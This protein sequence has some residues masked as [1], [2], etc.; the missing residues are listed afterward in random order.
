MQEALDLAY[1]ADSDTEVAELFIEPPDSHV[2]TDE[3]SADEDDGGLAG[4]LSARQLTAGAEIR[5]TN[6]RRIGG[7][8][9]DLQTELH[10]GIEANIDNNH[11]VLGKNLVLL[12]TDQPDRPSLNIHAITPDPTFCDGDFI[13][14]ERDFPEMKLYKL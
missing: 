4:N 10:H 11:D 9:E 8:E 5:L 7:I 12:S 1:E 3:D 13:F 2:L 6:S 14:T